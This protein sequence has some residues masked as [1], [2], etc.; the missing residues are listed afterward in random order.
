MICSVNTGHLSEKK[1]YNKQKVILRRF[2]CHENPLG[3]I[4]WY[5]YIHVYAHY[6]GAKDYDNLNDNSSVINTDTYRRK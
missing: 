4:Q 2:K 5:S 3:Y 1:P 6:I